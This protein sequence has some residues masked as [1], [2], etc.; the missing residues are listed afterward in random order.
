[1]IKVKKFIFAN[2][3][4]P[5]TVIIGLL[6][7][8]IMLIFALPMF[9]VL[10]N[11][12]GVTT[13][14]GGQCPGRDYNCVAIPCPSGYKIECSPQTLDVYSSYAL[15][16]KTV[17]SAL[18]V[19][20]NTGPASV[21]VATTPDNV[22]YY[23]ITQPLNTRLSCGTYDPGDGLCKACNWDWCRFWPLKNWRRRMWDA[24]EK[25]YEQN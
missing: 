16:T 13:S 19:C 9:G 25:M 2:Q 8:A 17:R 20:G 23:C 18:Q 5:V 3:V 12:T 4:F 21:C 15:T 14:Q 1:M 22:T 6:A 10:P 24:C 11:C 7:L